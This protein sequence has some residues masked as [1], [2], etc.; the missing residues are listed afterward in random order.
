[1]ARRPAESLVL[2]RRE[3]LRHVGYGASYALP[4]LLPAPLR[5]AVWPISGSGAGLAYAPGDEALADFRLTPVY[6]SSSPLDE[7]L[8]LAAP[9]TDAYVA[10]KFAAELQGW[11][12]ALRRLLKEPAKPASELAQLLDDSLQANELT[13]PRETRSQRSGSS[14]ELRKRDYV[15]AARSGKDA[16]VPQLANYFEPLGTIEIADFA[17]TSLRQTKSEPLELGAEV[18]YTLVGTRAERPA[19]PSL[20]AQR[21]GIWRMSW[22]RNA[23][24]QWRATK[25]IFAEEQIAEAAAPLFVDISEQVFAGIESYEP[26]LLQ[27][28]DHWR[29]VLDGA[30]GVDVYGNNGIAAGDFDG[31]GRDD[32]Y[33]CQPSGLPNR[34]YR[35]RGDGSFEDVTEKAGVGVLDATACA[36]FA[37]FEN[38]GL[39]DL[40]VV[41]DSGPLL[42][43]NQGKGKFTPQPDA[44][45]FAKAPQGTFT[46][47]AVADYDRDGRLD[48]Y[49]C[50]YTY[51]LGLDQ[52]HYP[53]PYFDARNG[54]LNFLFRN[55]GNA[56]FVDRTEAAGLNAENDRFSFAC[57][58]G[59]ISGSGG[60]DLYV[61]NDFG[62]SNLYRN[63]GDGTFATVS[64]E[65]GVNVPGAGMS[66]C[67]CDF[68]N[69]GKQDVYVS[70]MW[71]A[72]GHRVS[73][74]EPFHTRDS[75]EIRSFYRGHARGNSLY[76]NKGG[77]KFENV[78]ESSGAAMG[79]WAWSSD[80][81]DFDHD[82]YSDLYIANG[83]V[84]G[85]AE[86]ELS[87]FFWRQV[88][89]NSPANAMPSA[90]YEH[91]W[92]AINEL[93]RSDHPWSGYE[94]NTLYLNN[95][96][97][98]FSDISG[99]SGLDLIEDGRAFAL[100]DLD[101][102]G[103]LEVIAKNRNAPQLRVFRNVMSEIG[104]AIAV[105][106]RGTKSNRD[107]IGAAITVRAGELRQTKYLQ[108]GTGFLSQHSKEIFFGLGRATG[109][110]SVTA[111][112]PSGETQEFPDVALNH[113]ITI[114]EGKSNVVATPFSAGS[115]QRRSETPVIKPKPL[116]TSVSTWLLDPLPAPDFSLSDLSGKATSLSGFRGH[117]VLLSFWA[118]AAPR[119]LEQLQE[120]QSHRAALSAGNVGLITLNVD[121]GADGSKVR[122]FSEKTGL[123]FS[124]VAATADVAGVYNILYRFLYDRRR[125]LPV[126]CSFL[127]DESGMIVK[128]YQGV[129]NTKQI[130]ADA[131]A[132]P[133]TY[134]ARVAN[135][136][137]FPG[138]L[139]NGKFK[140]ND[141][142]YG[143]AL[144]Q[145]G[146]LDQAAESL[147]QVIAAQPQNTEAYYNLG[148]LYLRK[149]NLAE[150]KR[151][152]EKTVKLR[153]E[154][155][156]AWN[157]LGMIAGQQNQYD[158][159]IRNFTQSLAKRPDY[160]IALLNLGNIHRR[161]GN[162]A[163]S[164]RLLNRAVELEP[165]NAEANYSLGMLYARQNDVSQATELLQKAVALRPDYA[166]AINNLG[167]LY[168]RQGKNSDAEQQFTTCIRVAPN[169]DQAYLNLARL[170]IL[171]QEKEKA[172]DTLQALL[173][174]QPEHKLA[175]QALGMLN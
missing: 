166:D 122:A 58:W 52:Y 100:A 86:P 41:R 37:D 112:W 29:T 66:A 140:R 53:S 141:F 80:A 94:R 13:S 85:T 59:D 163:E 164:T 126:P 27:G 134:E 57:A 110:I 5:A 32:I 12:E 42:F 121:P 175:Q 1:M 172:R 144:F 55:E 125:D 82:G 54:P 92:N 4:A 169:F 77:S 50:L 157:N 95:R 174:L 153:P 132:I 6:P 118:Q 167:V 73:E 119:S 34:L 63:N 46:H 21:I 49:F 128:V 135:A 60:P 78:S 129:A 87:S 148:T 45:A 160:V 150:A 101:G 67:W 79:R 64:Q 74:S 96:D 98:S 3:F 65:A 26:Q 142:T 136:L 133:R 28:A 72:A 103:R 104:D 115:G 137:P 61:A 48:V 106:L 9:G 84:S 22:Q 56:R 81:W 138:T 117:P 51:Y 2:N 162:V 93:I 109:K 25:W 155:P 105:R 97:G 168:V 30:S 71:S 76:R 154:Y 131:A 158:E 24:P 88:V 139:Y 171:M 83:Y 8:R 19:S 68:D 107:A 99:V 11:F 18:R 16:F 38:R 15:A 20:C 170:Y 108:A 91:G 146:Y 17:I 114:E 31:D 124:I 152:L 14:I 23:S 44:F 47:A 69:D 149:N 10:E 130:V 90:N 36:I 102:D 165:E 145:H 147:Q 62:R 151:Y 127:L 120:L 113:R 33:I 143:V 123:T 161:Q 70:N 39:Q 35:N 40:L 156:E 111:R 75:A 173:K 159:A 116:P 89:G 43:L 7:M